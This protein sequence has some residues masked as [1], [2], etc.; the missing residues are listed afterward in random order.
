MLSDA[1]TL[2]KKNGCYYARYFAKY[3][4]FETLKDAE[5]S[6]IECLKCKKCFKEHCREVAK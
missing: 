3:Y 5:G 4:D 1:R 6:G 2:H